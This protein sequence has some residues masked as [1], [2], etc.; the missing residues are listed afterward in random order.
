L[1]GKSE[2]YSGENGIDGLIEHLLWINRQYPQLVKEGV[3]AKCYS[4]G[5][6]PIE[7]KTYPCIIMD[8]V[9]GENPDDL[10][11]RKES[12]DLMKEIASE[13]EIQLY[14]DHDIRKTYE[15]A[16]DKPAPLCCNRKNSFRMSQAG[17]VIKELKESNIII[18]PD[19]SACIIDYDG[20]VPI[21]Y[22][23]QNNPSH[24]PQRAIPIRTKWYSEHP[25]IFDKRTETRPSPEDLAY[26]F[27]ADWDITVL[28]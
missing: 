13:E 11:I 5:E 26:W 1:R 25:Y 17:L 23:W 16:R 22:D 9:S 10:S 6:Y 12:R 8:Y 27:T 15:T 19:G 18:R 7:D 14:L 2:P 3:I 28:G 4:K 20:A 24:I 21:G